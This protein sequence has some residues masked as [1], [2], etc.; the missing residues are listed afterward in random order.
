M[1]PTGPDTKDDCAGEAQQQYTGLGEGCL[2]MRGQPECEWRTE[3]ELLILSRVEC[4]QHW[5]TSDIVYSVVR[6][7]SASA[8]LPPVTVYNFITV[9]R[10]NFILLLKASSIPGNE[11]HFLSYF[12]NVVLC[13]LHLVCV[14]VYP[15]PINFE[16]LN[17]SLWNVVRTSWHLSPSQHRT[18]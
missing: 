1:V 10:N 13:D 6:I 9:N 14:S 4:E 8:P 17:Q 5:H 3:A 15:S 7:C 18:S 12:R 16:C 2:G 11:S